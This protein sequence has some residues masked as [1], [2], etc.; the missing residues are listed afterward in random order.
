MEHCKEL[1][2]MAAQLGAPAKKTLPNVAEQ[3]EMPPVDELLG[4]VE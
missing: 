1:D 4:S 3:F 2:D